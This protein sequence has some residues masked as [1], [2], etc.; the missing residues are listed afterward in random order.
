L[1]SGVSRE[2]FS[3]GVMAEKQINPPNYIK[4]R[5]VIK[6]KRR[7]W[8]AK[9]AEFWSSYFIGKDILR[10]FG[11]QP[12]S[13]FWVNGTRFTCN[14]ITYAF[15]FKDRYKIYAPYDKENKWLSNTRKTDIQGYSQLPTKGERL[16][17]TSSLKDVMC[18]NAA[19]YHSIALQSE[20]EVPDEKLISKLKDRFKTIEILYDNDFHKKKNP[21]QTMAKK[22]CEIYNFKNICIPDKFRAKDSS[23]LVKSLGS[24]IELKAILQ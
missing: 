18:L 7:P 4:K 2:S 17:I 20:M 5:V 19:G 21:G 10:S 13:H 11:V 16:I 23:D 12:I 15:K 22:I 24:L 3:M 14:T 1:S 8:S 6:K 9:D